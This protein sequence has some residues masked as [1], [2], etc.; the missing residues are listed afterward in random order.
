MFIIKKESLSRNF[1]KLFLILLILFIPN[2]QIISAKETKKNISLNFNNADIDDILRALAHQNKL[3]LILLDEVKGKRKTFHYTQI[4]LEDALT[5]VLVNTG[6]KFVITKDEKTI[7]ISAVD[8][9]KID[10]R[11]FRLKRSDSGRLKKL[12]EE[13][14]PD[15][16]K[17]KADRETNSLII[18]DTFSNFNKII[19]VVN[20]LDIENTEET[21]LGNVEW[22]EQGKEFITDVFICHYVEAV[23]IKEILDKLTTEGGSI[24]ADSFS[25]S[26]L[27]RD[28]PLVVAKIRDLI[29]K[30]DKETPQVMIDAELVEINVGRITELG[31]RWFY[32]GNKGL[33]GTMN[34][35]Y[36]T[37]PMPE[38]VA[39]YG[40][41]SSNTGGSL[42][43]GEVSDQFRGV[44]NAL[45]TEN[46]ADLLANPR[47]T[48]LN[49]E[50]AKIEITEKFPYE[51]VSGHDEHGNPEYTV[52]FL[53]IG[54]ILTVTPSIKEDI[55]TLDLE[56][57]V[58]YYQ[59]ENA[60]IPIQS[61]RKATTKVNVR[62]GKTIVIGGLLSNKKTRTAYK[63]PILG[64]LP[65][66]GRLFRTDKDVVDKVELV[67]FV[68]PHIFSQDKAEKM[69]IEE[70]EKYRE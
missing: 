54:I 52:N 60:G 12:L 70:R 57:Q 39:N 8:K 2:N 10:T 20:T 34:H 45:I 62:D 61:L 63:I 36:Q 51:Q 14:I 55:V 49:N 15:I 26:L 41:A 59:G 65:L 50:K 40:I 9:L 43:F 38:G 33:I 35:K 44:I 48:V 11:I 53:D 7:E 47:I 23:K 19:G 16:G 24:G 13:G 64:N 1:L 21:T 3:N 6:F 46:K 66:I 31:V 28:S 32:L 56:P 69:G 29:R 22:T 4:S 17:I 18:T 30:L 42:L 67:I 25:N 5:N 58:S 27:V 68:T 37:E